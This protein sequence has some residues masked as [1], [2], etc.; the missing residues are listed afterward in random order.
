MMVSLG[1]S[2]ARVSGAVDAQTAAATVA[3]GRHSE[4]LVNLTKDNAAL[5]AEVARAPPTIASLRTVK[6]RKTVPAQLEDP[7]SKRVSTPGADGAG[8]V[9]ND[10]GPGNVVKQVTRDLLFCTSMEA[11][12][13]TSRMASRPLMDMLQEVVQL[14]HVSPG[15]PGI[16]GSFVEKH[17]YDQAAEDLT[18]DADGGSVVNAKPNKAK[19]DRLKSIINNK[20]ESYVRQL[21]WMHK[22]VPDVLSTPAAE[23]TVERM[24]TVVLT[25]PQ[26]QALHA[27][28]CKAA[29]D[30]NYALDHPI[31][32][33]VKARMNAFRDLL[34]T[35]AVNNRI[36][37]NVDVML[38]SEPFA[39]RMAEA[40]KRI[41]PQYERD[42]PTP[43]RPG[44]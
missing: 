5:R 42:F 15:H 10:A 43:A 34:C 32:S 38:K 19:K 16:F 11:E 8:R 33:P 41:R 7:G 28:I 20:A 6:R 44:A 3:A 39:G 9:G 17:V 27:A 25:A 37:S 29:Q 40:T 36:I 2:M 1:Q 35:L 26:R 30:V 12:L 4:A 23:A 14:A 18:A 31:L 21:F 24:S 22:V 13:L